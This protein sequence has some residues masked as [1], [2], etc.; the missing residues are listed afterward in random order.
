VRLLLDTQVYLWFLADS[1]KLSRK[2][3][4]QISNAGAVYVSAAS[5]WE[6]AIKIGVGKLNVAVD[7]LVNNIQGSGFLPLPVQPQH[8]ALVAALPRHH[9]DPFDRILVAQAI[10]ETIR[11]LTVDSVLTP[12]TELVVQVHK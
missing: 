6:A 9:R 10:C 1:P 8:A 4:E 7:E 5:I 12:Y 3:R 2:T 11:L